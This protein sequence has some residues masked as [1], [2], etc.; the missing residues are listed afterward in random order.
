MVIR[1]G[2]K[3]EYF[4]I[5]QDL[6]NLYLKIGRSPL[7]FLQ[8]WS[9]CITTIIYACARPTSCFMQLLPSTVFTYW[10]LL[11]ASSERDH[12]YI[13][14]VSFGPL[15]LLLL[16][17]LLL[18]F[19]HVL[20]CSSSLV[21]GRDDCSVQCVFMFGMYIAVCLSVS[22]SVCV[23][24]RCLWR[25][26]TWWLNAVMS[27][28]ARVE[29]ADIKRDDFFAELCRSIMLY[30]LFERSFYFD[31]T[32]VRLLGTMTIKGSLHGASG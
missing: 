25:G 8:P 32:P 6:K 23:D 7:F 17:L 24:L 15:L 9:D 14:C 28:W 1:T 10:L 30:A 31:S 3:I 29:K 26:L 5:Q 16:P 2:K 13:I 27:M 20:R 12:R 22:L 19:H 4:I 18:L 21:S 11:L